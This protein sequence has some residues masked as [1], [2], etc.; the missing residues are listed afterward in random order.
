MLGGSGG[1]VVIGLLV[2]VD[3]SEN[4]VVRSGLVDDEHTGVGT[5]PR[6]TLNDNIQHVVGLVLLVVL[7]RRLLRTGST[8]ALSGGGA[9]E[10][11]F[12]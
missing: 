11:G 5:R 12:V 9:R 10:R 3:V 7:L 1:R 8:T 4:D 6:K 2:R